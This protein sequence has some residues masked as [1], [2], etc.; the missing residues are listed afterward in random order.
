LPVKLVAP[1]TDWKRWHGESFWH[2][3]VL[4]DADNG[5]AKASAV[6]TLQLRTLDIQRFVRRMGHVSSMF[7]EEVA[8]T[9]AAVVEYQ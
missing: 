3:H 7:M 1:I 2:L 9:I 4:P 6:T 8:A 5:L